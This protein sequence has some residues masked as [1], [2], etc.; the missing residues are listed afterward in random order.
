MGD[1]VNGVV[2][3][4]SVRKDNL[5][6]WEVPE[7][8]EVHVTTDGDGNLWASGHGLVGLV[9]V[10]SVEAAKGQDMVIITTAGRTHT[11]GKVTGIRCTSKTLGEYDANGFWAGPS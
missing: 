1:P 5:W 2:T 4:Q 8:G 9:A 3:V 11:P 6:G 7:S 10:A